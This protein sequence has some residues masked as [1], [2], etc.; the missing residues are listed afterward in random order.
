MARPDLDTNRL[1]DE[2][3]RGDASARSRLLDRHRGRLRRMVA[4]R[5]DRRLSARLDPSDVV[6]EA[7]ADAGRKLDNYLRDRPMPFYPWLRQLAWER[8]VKLRRRHTAAK[9]D[10]GREVTFDLPEQSA[11][12]LAERLAATAT[13]PEQ[14]LVRK[15]LRERVQGALE[16]LA[17]TDRELLV[18]RHAEQLSTKEAAAVLGVS[19]TAVKAR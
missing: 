16:R 12:E 8:L 14:R 11:L 6:Q 19:E 7:L 3:S 15:E 5:L 10:I 1:L 13:G 18:L 2:V 4:I 17:P 9:R